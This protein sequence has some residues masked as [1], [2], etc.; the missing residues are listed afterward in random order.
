MELLIVILLILILLSQLLLSW[1]VIAIE[2]WLAILTNI[3]PEPKPEEAKVTDP[4]TKPKEIYSSTSHIVVPKTPTEIRNQN[5][6]KIKEG[7]EYGD[8]AKR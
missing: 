5:F 2:K 7:I 3:E 1:S 4:F 6:K 8:I